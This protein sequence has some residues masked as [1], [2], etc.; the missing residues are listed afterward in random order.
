MPSL[1]TWQPTIRQTDDVK[2]V[3]NKVRTVLE[4]EKAR[5]YEQIGGYPPPIAACDQQ[6]NDL[7]EKQTKILR[8][9]ARLKEAE[10]E[11]LTAGDPSKVIYE[12]I[13][14]SPYIDSETEQTIKPP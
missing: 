1:E 10:A 13:R 6:F 14:S 9:L 11:S 4:H 3:W 5:I 2:S 8:E 12:F 7:L